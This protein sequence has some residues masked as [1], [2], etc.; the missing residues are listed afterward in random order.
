MHSCHTGNQTLLP[1]ILFSKVFFF[2]FDRKAEA[3]PRAGQGPVRGG[4]PVR[5]L[6]RPQSLRLKV[7]GAARRQTLER[8]GVGVSLHQVRRWQELSSN[9]NS[10]GATVRSTVMAVEREPNASGGSVCAYRLLK[11][12]RC[13]AVNL[14]ESS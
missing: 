8:P 4:V 10:S 11:L 5:Q 7:G 14:G 12:L 9:V 3:R 13:Q 2:F 6:G 1:P